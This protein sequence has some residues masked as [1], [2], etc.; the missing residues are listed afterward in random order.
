[1]RG[2]DLEIEGF[3]DRVGAGQLVGAEIDL[4]LRLIGRRAADLGLVDVG[5]DEVLTLD[6][7]EAAGKDSDNRSRAFD[8]AGRNLWIDGNRF[9]NTGSS[10]GKDGEGIVCRARE[11][12]PVY[13]TAGSPAK[14]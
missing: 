11:G 14:V 4:S 1:M 10:P 9:N 13:T 8:L 2:L 12:T 3:E 6:G 7:W 5:G